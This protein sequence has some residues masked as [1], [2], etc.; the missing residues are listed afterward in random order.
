MEKFADMKVILWNDNLYVHEDDYD[1]FIKEFAPKTKTN[2]TIAM[3]Y[4]IDV[5]KVGDDIY[6]HMLKMAKPYDAEKHREQTKKRDEDAWK[7]LDDF[8]IMTGQKVAQDETDNL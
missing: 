2:T 1:I 8:L 5:F 6:K 3:L 7:V 4:G